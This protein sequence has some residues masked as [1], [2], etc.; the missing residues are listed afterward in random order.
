MNIELGYSIGIGIGR[1]YHNSV[2]SF[3]NSLLYKK[4]IVRSFKIQIIYLFI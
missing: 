1:F 4:H 2:S 3:K